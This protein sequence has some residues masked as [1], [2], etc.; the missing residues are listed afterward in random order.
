[1]NNIKMTAGVVIGGFYMQAMI[2][3]CSLFTNPKPTNTKD[4]RQKRNN[5]AKRKYK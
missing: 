4:P 2:I 5:N 3:H 1:M